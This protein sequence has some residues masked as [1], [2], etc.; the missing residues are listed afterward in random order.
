MK[1][2][3]TIKTAI[4]ILAEMDLDKFFR[5]LSNVFEWWKSVEELED[6]SQ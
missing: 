4:N 1:N 6:E 3:D 2:Y 5:V